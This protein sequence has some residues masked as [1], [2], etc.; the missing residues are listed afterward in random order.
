MFCGYRLHFRNK[1]LRLLILPFIL[2]GS[3]TTFGQSALLDNFLGTWQGSGTLFNRPAEFSM[4]WERSLKDKFLKLTFRNPYIDAQ[5]FYMSEDARN[6]KGTWADSRGVILPLTAVV[7]DTALITNWGTPEMEQGR[8]HYHLVEPGVIKVT[9]FVLRDGEWTRFGQAS[10]MRN[11]GVLEK[12]RWLLGTWRRESEGSI[13]EE[14]WRKLSDRTYEG[15]SVRISKANGDTVFTESLLLT[16]MEGSL[17]YVAKVAENPHPVSFMMT[18]LEGNRIVFENAKH[19]FPQKI[20]Y[21]LKDA[22]SFIAIVSGP[23]NGE[24]RSIE[25]P[26]KRKD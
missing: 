14:S 10:Y 3:Q 8:A 4:T 1:L 7:S 5:A 23:S 16:E 6:Y 22:D 18:A 2:C 20:V 15:Q 9:D 25:F 24:Q 17:F 12:T 21:E 11:N 26:F 19:D 13:T